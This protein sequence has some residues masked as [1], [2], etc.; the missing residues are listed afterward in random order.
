MGDVDAQLIE[1]PAFDGG[2]RTFR[3]GGCSR[4]NRQRLH[5]LIRVRRLIEI[6]KI[7]H[8]NVLSGRWFRSGRRLDDGAVR[9]QVWIDGSIREWINHGGANR[10]D[11][12]R[13]SNK[14]RDHDEW[15]P[16]DA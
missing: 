8:A 9:K 1:R 13:W 12:N 11:A 16:N 2:A 3:F 6:L 4:R 10:P 14:Y 15:Q 7:G 5:F